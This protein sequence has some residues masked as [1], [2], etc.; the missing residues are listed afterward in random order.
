MPLP[1]TSSTTKPKESWWSGREGYAERIPLYDQST[2]NILDQLLQRGSQGLQNQ[3]Y[4]PQG[5]PLINQL[6]GKLS[7]NKFDFGPIA[8]REVSRF[9]QETIPSLAER[10]TAMGSGGSQRSSAFQGALGQAGAGLS[11]ALASLASQYGLQERGLDQ[12][13]LQLLLG[14]QLSNSGQQQNALLAMLQAGTQ[15]RFN[16]I[17]NQAQPGFKQTFAG[18]LGSAIGSAANL[19]LNYL[20]GGG[21]GLANNLASGLS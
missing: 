11:E 1:N 16:T 4:Q 21:Y 14:N 10:F 12:S 9:N 3:N 6:L 2:Q 5:Q 7:T 19:G 17:Y 20:T 8:A 15:P 13:L 18:G